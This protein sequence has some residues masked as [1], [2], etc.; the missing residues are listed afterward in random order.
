MVDSCR[1]H[2]I[3]IPRTLAAAGLLLL[4]LAGCDQQPA[5]PQATVVEESKEAEPARPRA[6]ASTDKKQFVGSKTCYDCHAKFYEIW[7]TSRHGLAMQPYSPAFAKR[8]LK[9]QVNEVVIGKQSFRAE[10]GEKQGWVRET[11]R[12]QGNPLPDRPR[13]GRQERLLFPHADAQG[14]LA[15]PA[16]G[17]RRPEADLVRHG[18]QRRASLPRSPPAGRRPCRGPIGS[19]PSTRPASTAT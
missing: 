11:E 17:L 9:P 14:P 16:R 15:G 10:I 12:R 13:H 1:I 2:P 19:S 4:V 3:D 6:A 18:G 7:S 5:K 8:E